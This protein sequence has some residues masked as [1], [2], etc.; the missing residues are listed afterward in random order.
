MNY[1][2]IKLGGMA[3]IEDKS[4]DWCGKVFIYTSH[5]GQEIR[6]DSKKNWKE[7]KEMYQ[8]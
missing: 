5:N 4:S 6:L 2:T 1:P 7:L 3:K 8:Q